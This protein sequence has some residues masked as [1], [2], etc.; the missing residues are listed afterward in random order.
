MTGFALVLEHDGD[1]VLRVAAD[2]WEVAQLG[3]RLLAA[4][5]LRRVSV[6]GAVADWRERDAASRTLFG[7]VA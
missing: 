5:G 1:P 3:A 4:L 6:S 7:A 2:E